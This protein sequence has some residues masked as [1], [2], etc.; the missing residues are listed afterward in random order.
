M[1]YCVVTCGL[2]GLGQ[3][4]CY[5][6]LC[7]NV[8]CLYIYESYWRAKALTASCLSVV[9]QHVILWEGVA[10][11][12]YPDLPLGSLLNAVPGSVGLGVCIVTSFQVILM[13]LVH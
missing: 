6:H 13:L 5:V 1:V 12:R 10:S 7:V 4:S 9:R 3:Q 8:Y 11:L 2:S